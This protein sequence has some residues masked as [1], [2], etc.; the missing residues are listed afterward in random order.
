MGFRKEQHRCCGRFEIRALWEIWGC[1]DNKWPPL[2]D[3]WITPTIYASCL[4]SVCMMIVSA[5][6]TLASYKG[7]TL[8]LNINWWIYY[9]LT[10]LGFINSCANLSI[11][12][13]SK[14][15]FVAGCFMQRQEQE[16]QQQQQQGEQR[17][18][19]TTSEVMSA[20]SGC[21]RLWEA[22]VVWAAVGSMAT[23]LLNIAFAY[24]LYR[25]KSQQRL[26]STASIHPHPSQRRVLTPPSYH[27]PLISQQYPNSQQQQKHM[28]DEDGFQVIELK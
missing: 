18:G 27:H 17:D 19:I 6:A 26:Y 13:I 7:H 14:D 22:T 1:V 28:T 20:I 9:V 16:Q 4:L 10:V 5:S 24:M 23:L 12:C 15:R 8:S 3:T 11:M 21:V 2:I 25:V